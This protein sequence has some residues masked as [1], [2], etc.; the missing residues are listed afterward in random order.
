MG[1]GLADVAEPCVQEVSIPWAA[2][3]HAEWVSAIGTI[4]V[5]LLALV[6]R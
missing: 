6:P 5:G 1:G 4:S 2:S 3:R